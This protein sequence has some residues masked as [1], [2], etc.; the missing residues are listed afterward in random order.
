MQK[1]ISSAALQNGSVVRIVQLAVVVRVG[2]QEAAAEAELLAREAHLLDRGLDRLHGQHGDA[3]QAVGVGLAVVGEPAVV[4]TAHRT[5]QAWIL[6]R[7]D[8]QAEARIEEGR[9]DAALLSCWH[10]L[11][12]CCDE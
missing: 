5:G 2:A 3:E 4:G 10:S 1:S 12:W 9:I 7:T 8:E 11:R 6:D